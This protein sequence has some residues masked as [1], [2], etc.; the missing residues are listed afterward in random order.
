M[1]LHESGPLRRAAALIIKS[2]SPMKEEVS[3]SDLY[4]SKQAAA[5]I[6]PS[7]SISLS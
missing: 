2:A 3:P 4:H 1:G 7:T 5:A 6:Y